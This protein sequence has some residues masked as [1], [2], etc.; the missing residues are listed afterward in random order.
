MSA[1]PPTTRLTDVGSASRRRSPNIAGT[2]RTDPASLR[3]RAHADQVAVPTN[4]KP[5]HAKL[6]PTKIMVATFPN[7]LRSAWW[8][9]LHASMTNPATRTTDQRHP[10]W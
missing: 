10:E 6:P 9:A 7:R 5:R 3:A 8:L 2:E 4:P 1:T